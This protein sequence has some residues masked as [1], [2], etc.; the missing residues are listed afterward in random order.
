M[1]DQ[2]AWPL[3]EAR[4]DLGPH[5]RSGRRHLVARR[6]PILGNQEAGGVTEQAVR[7]VLLLPSEMQPRQ[8][9]SLLGLG[10]PSFPLANHYNHIHVG[11]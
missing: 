6:N 2:R 8:V 10:G 3:R 1:P 5:L 11:F 9:I 7:N 4:R